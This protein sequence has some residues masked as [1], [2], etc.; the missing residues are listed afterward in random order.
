MKEAGV[1]LNA[2]DAMRKEFV[3][4]AKDTAVK[5]L[6]LTIASSSNTFNCR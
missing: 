3:G 2:T 5:D 4:H 6:K 1:P